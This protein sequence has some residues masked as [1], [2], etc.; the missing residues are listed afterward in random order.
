M[1]PIFLNHF[2]E[3]IRIPFQNPLFR[4]CANTP[5]C[6]GSG[7]PY[8]KMHN[9]CPRPQKLPNHGKPSIQY[10]VQVIGMRKTEISI[11]VEPVQKSL[12]AL[13]RQMHS[14]GSQRSE[15]QL[16]FRFGGT[17]EE[18]SRIE[19]CVFGGVIPS[20]RGRGDHYGVS[21][22]RSLRYRQVYS[23]LR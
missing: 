15:E 9:F 13:L 4:T 23:I 18:H 7:L 14:R 5:T 10:E 17:D 22:K 6:R 12:I 2:L 3:D 8:R 1:L 19:F 20:V 16:I 21:V 11:L